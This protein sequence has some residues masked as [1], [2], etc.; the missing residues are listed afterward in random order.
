MQFVWLHIDAQ[1]NSMELR[2]SIRS[3]QKNFS[4]QAQF[5]VVGDIPPWYSGH[6]ILVPKYSVRRVPRTDRRAFLDTQNK[7]WTA[8]NHPEVQDEFVWMMD[9]VF[10]LQPTT[11]EDL[12]TPRFDPWYQQNRAREWHRLIAATF[13]ALRSRG[14]TNLQYGT[15][16]PHHFEKQKMLD[17]FSLYN[18]PRQLYLFEILYGN[19][20]RT[21]AIPYGGNWNGTDYHF[22]LRRLLKRPRTTGE[23][24]SLV[25]DSNVLN[26]QSV[27]FGPQIKTW[28]E[29]KF[30]EPSGVE[31]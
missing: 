3:V 15:H 22:F 26:Y 27:C 30:P 10:L 11:I 16:L 6:A 28:L 19:H 23:M 4:G 21:D 5:T 7:I 25:G 17:L 13:T 2:H 1:D 14:K 31:T 8:V 29:R 9:D 20:Y 12:K 18:Y 24:D